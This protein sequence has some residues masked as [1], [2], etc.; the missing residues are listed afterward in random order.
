MFFFYWKLYY[1]DLC[2]LIVYV[3]I[4]IFFFWKN[5]IRVEITWYLSYWRVL[6]PPK[7]IINMLFKI[8]L[9][10]IR[11]EIWLLLN[12]MNLLCIFIFCFTHI[13]IYF[14]FFI[15]FFESIWHYLINQ[16]INKLK[17]ER[18]YIWKGWLRKEVID[19]SGTSQ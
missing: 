14:S 1:W 7:Y 13:I 12:I 11:K 17:R 4:L 5:I 8:I 2:N 16:Y 3:S 18:K 15:E 10:Y 9:V 6:T 19:H